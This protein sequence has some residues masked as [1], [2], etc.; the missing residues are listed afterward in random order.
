MVLTAGT[1]ESYIGVFLENILYGAYISVFLESCSIL[2]ARRK[3]ANARQ[4]YLMVTAV[5]MVIFITTCCV[6]DTV[7]CVVALD[8]NG[9]NF[10]PP[11]TNIDIATNTSWFL[12]TAVADAFIIFRTFI[13]W[14]R[15]WFAIII[16]S[17]L[18]VAN[19]GSSIWLIISLK[20]F[21]PA[22][23]S[24]FQ[25][26]LI[27][28]TN[29]FISLSLATNLLCTGLI[30]FRIFYTYRQIS[31]L[32]SSSGSPS[33]SIRIISIL[34]ESATMYTLLLTGTLIS[35]GLNSYVNYILFDCTPPTIHL[36]GTTALKHRLPPPTPM[37][38]IRDGSIVHAGV[39][40]K[41]SKQR[42]RLKSRRFLPRRYRMSDIA[43][44][45]F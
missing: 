18:Y 11:N 23:E 19:F 22:G 34:V 42:R 7:R 41:S 2:W 28:S 4:I 31:S 38:R 27:K 17:L 40:T 3:N 8:S 14:N 9:L 15:N 29:V 16:P 6:I 26:M 10:G 24:V 21:D 45:T 32:L 12:V 35:E 30:S 36:L 13:V 39:D 43:A 1:K 25:H 5:L 37:R 20:D 44:Q 33:N